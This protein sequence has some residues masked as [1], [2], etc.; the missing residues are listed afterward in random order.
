MHCYFS[1]FLRLKKVPPKTATVL[2]F[3]F[4]C[5]LL[6][7]ASTLRAHPLKKRFLSTRP[8]MLDQKADTKTIAHTGALQEK[9]RKTDKC[10]KVKSIRIEYTLPSLRTSFSAEVGFSK[11]SC[12]LV[13]S[14]SE[15]VFGVPWNVKKRKHR[16]CTKRNDIE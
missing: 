13:F 15:F 16:N 9:A 1:S 2:G 8:R 10:G 7:F 5:S 3:L 11:M 4:F 12:F 6:S 14:F